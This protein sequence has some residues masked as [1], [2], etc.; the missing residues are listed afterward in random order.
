MNWATLMVFGMLGLSMATVSF[1]VYKLHIDSLG[2]RS[3]SFE[4]CGRAP[5]RDSTIEDDFRDV[6]SIINLREIEKIFHDYL[7][8]DQQIAN[9][10]SFINEQIKF[11]KREIDVMPETQIM[12]EYLRAIGLRSGYW[13]EAITQYWQNLPRYKGTDYGVTYGGLTT[14]IQKMIARLPKEDLRRLLQS[15][16]R[17]SANFQHF[18]NLINSDL[19]ADMC[20]KIAQ[21]E[22]LGRHYYWAVEGSLEAIFAIELL[23]NLRS[24]LLLVELY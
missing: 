20:M 9:T 22:V 21:N 11:I 8:H 6:L 14:M 7:M 16:A 4:D 15:K 2:T 12:L 19:F 23:R 17:S 13:A 3:T 5:S 1:L 10:Y 24:Y 18:L